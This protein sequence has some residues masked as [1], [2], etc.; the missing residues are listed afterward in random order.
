MLDKWHENRLI[1]VESKLLAWGGAQRKLPERNQG[2]QLVSVHINIP[3]DQILQTILSFLRLILGSFSQLTQQVG[4]YLGIWGQLGL[5]LL[6]VLLGL[7]ILYQLLRILML[8]ILRAL[9]PL[10]ILSLTL[11]F[12]VILTS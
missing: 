11:F 7:W 9:L 12:L 8:F 1:K 4:D 10:A 5:N 3:W 2:V 6:V